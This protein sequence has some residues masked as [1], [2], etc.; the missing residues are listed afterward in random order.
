MGDLTQKL[1]D[2]R[3]QEAFSLLIKHRIPLS[4]VSF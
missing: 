2:P 3:L 1:A 4:E